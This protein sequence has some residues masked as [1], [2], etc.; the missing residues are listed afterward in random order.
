MVSTTVAHRGWRGNE[1]I[2]LVAL[3]LVFLLGTPGLGI[4]TRDVSQTDAVAGAVYGVAFFAVLASLVASFRWP[5]AASWV[6]ILGGGASAAVT[7][8]DLTG[9]F[10]GPPPVG[11]AVVDVAVAILGAAVV[12]RSLAHR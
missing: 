4:E 3:M 6:G 1:R 12:R 11:M 9:V 8:L 10:V 7:L 5:V 2:L